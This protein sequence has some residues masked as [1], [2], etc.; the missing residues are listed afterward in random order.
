MN[1]KDLREKSLSE[2]TI[3]E[4]REITNSKGREEE[5]RLY[6]HSRVADKFSIYLTRLFLFFDVSANQVSLI[7]IILGTLATIFL[8]VGS[9]WFNITFYIIFLIAL[10]IDYSDGE[11]AKY[12]MWRKGKKKYTLKG[13]FI[14]NASHSIID[15]FI[16]LGIG[17]GAWNRF[18]QIYYFYFGIAMALMILFSHVFKL[19]IYETIILAKRKDL[20]KDAKKTDSNSIKKIRWLHNLFKPQTVLYSLFFWTLI[21]NVLHWFLI[22]SVVVFAIVFVRDMVG[23]FKKLDKLDKNEKKPKK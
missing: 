3:S 14:E 11:I 16:F 10:F 1:N 21:F 12:W 20:L 2:L 9:Y 5:R 17:I 22:L 18:D 15:V 8:W 6:I 19:R 13:L 4:M 7:W 23:L